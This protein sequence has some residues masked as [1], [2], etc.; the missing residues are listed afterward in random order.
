MPF[1][2][3]VAYSNPDLPFE[4]MNDIAPEIKRAIICTHGE[5]TPSYMYIMEMRKIKE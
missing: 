5:L 2:K 4:E 1:V 3:G